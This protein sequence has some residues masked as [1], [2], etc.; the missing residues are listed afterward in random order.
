MV[1]RI[2]DPNNPGPCKQVSVQLHYI[3]EGRLKPMSKVK[4]ADFATALALALVW[5]PVVAQAANL[6]VVERA[7][8]DATSVHAG[9]KADNLGDMLTF[10]NEVFDQSNKTKVGSDQGYCV[11]V[12][13]GKSYECHWTLFLPGGQIVVDGPFFADDDSTLAIIGGTG[14]Y[15]RVRGEMRLHARDA[16][17]SS[18][19]F[20]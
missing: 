4:P 6:K 20:T 18:Y 5:Q 19:D 12:V 1:D 13:L 16:Q 11:R 3:P 9:P 14:A 7:T 17:G 10:A 8:T 15:R 2:L